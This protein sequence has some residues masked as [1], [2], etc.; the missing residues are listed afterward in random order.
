MCKV[1]V[2]LEPGS[3]LAGKMVSGVMFSFQF[4][5]KIKLCPSGLI[6][7]KY[8]QR[9]Q[10]SI[11]IYVVFFSSCI[12]AVIYVFLLF[13]MCSHLHFV[14]TS[15]LISQIMTRP[16]SPAA[17]LPTLTI[18]KRFLLQWHPTW[19]NIS[20]HRCDVY[21]VHLY[22][23]CDTHFVHLY[24]RCDVYLVYLYH[25]CDTH[26]VHLYYRCDA[27]PVFHRCIANPVHLLQATWL[28]WHPSDNGS[29]RARVVVRSTDNKTTHVMAIYTVHI[30]T[31]LY[32]KKNIA[33]TSIT[34]QHVRVLPTPT[35]ISLEVIYSTV[36]LPTRSYAQP[37]NRQ[38]W[39]RS[40][41]P[42]RIQNHWTVKQDLSV[43]TQHK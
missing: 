13:Q 2:S 27:N 25:M 31:K 6:E 1:C 10:A 37:I 29:C 4:C 22:H 23:R 41:R 26:F 20:E 39:P 43:V 9:L 42:S 5:V 36:S 15:S 34:T 18:A 40:S 16:S 11:S 17:M 32:S 7:C 38:V 12:V 14:C 21:L 24:H 3:K 35:C 8:Q 30:F 19:M 28:A 33:K